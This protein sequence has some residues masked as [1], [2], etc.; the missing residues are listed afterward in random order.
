[1]SSSTGLIV[2]GSPEP[3][4]IVS[5]SWSGTSPITELLNHVAPGDRVKRQRIH[6]VDRCQVVLQAVVVGAHQMIGR[7]R[8]DSFVAVMAGVK[9]Q[10]C[11]AVDADVPDTQEQRA[12]R[13]AMAFD[14]KQFARRVVLSDHWI[15][16]RELAAHAIA[17]IGASHRRGPRQKRHRQNNNCNGSHGNPR[18]TRENG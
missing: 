18:S 4:L 10:L 13:L 3:S 8:A 12:G 9:Q 15:E 1:M 6:G 7:R 2:A 11:A 17:G 5:R 16:S 14:A